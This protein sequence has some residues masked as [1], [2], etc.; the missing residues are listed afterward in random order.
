[1]LLI[2]E[3]FKALVSSVAH[4]IEETGRSET[5]L[6]RL[7]GVEQIEDL[8]VAQWTR[9]KEV[10]DLAKAQRRQPTGNDNAPGN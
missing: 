3:V 5:T 7:V 1:M 8:N 4:L 2:N 10:L 6:L 9:C